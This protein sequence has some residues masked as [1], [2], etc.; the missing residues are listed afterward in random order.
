M[1]KITVINGSPRKNGATA[2]LLKMMVAH[3]NM[4]K[5]IDVT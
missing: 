1:I 4:K 2:S 3:L 5:D